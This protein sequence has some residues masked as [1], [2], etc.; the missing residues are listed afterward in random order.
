MF[1]ILFNYKMAIHAKSKIEKK[2]KFHG[3]I[4][5]MSH[6]T[7]LRSAVSVFSEALLHYVV[8]QN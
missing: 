8:L 4:Y 6:C 5:F 3:S 2:K 1:A 7:K